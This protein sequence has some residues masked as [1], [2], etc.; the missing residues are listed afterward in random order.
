MPTDSRRFLAMTSSSNYGEGVPVRSHV[1]VLGG[2]AALVIAVL[3]FIVVTGA[4][5]E[6]RFKRCVQC[7]VIWVQHSYLGYPWDTYDECSHTLWHQKNVSD[8]EHLWVGVITPWSQQDAFGR[9][10]GAASN[11]DNWPAGRL[12]PMQQTDVYK[13]I[14]DTAEA[15]ELF[16]TLGNYQNAQSPQAGIIAHSLKRW[17]EEDQFQTA[18]DDWK[19]QQRAEL[20]QLLAPLADGN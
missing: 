6:R 10:I 19:E 15:D 17:A 7:R 14:G 5:G 2:L 13:H 1:V 8:H 16:A 3:G 20:G 11:L 18:W 12:T 9:N 4:C